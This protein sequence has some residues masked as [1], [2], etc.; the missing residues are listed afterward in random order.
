MKA[1]FPGFYNPLTNEYCS[2][3]TQMNTPRQSSTTTGFIACGGSDFFN[4]YYHYEFIIEYFD[5]YGYYY[6]PPPSPTSP[7]YNC[8]MF[9]PSSGT[10][11]KYATWYPSFP[12]RWRHV[13]WMSS[14]GLF[15]IGGHGLG[16]SGC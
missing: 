3:T 4:Y 9:D 5:Y 14:I 11:L 10:W 13:A 16:Q 6:L 15:L 12:G 2:I 7:A 8:E 1:A